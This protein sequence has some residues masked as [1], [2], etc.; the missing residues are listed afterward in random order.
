LLAYAF[1]TITA[2]QALNVR[3]G[4]TLTFNGDPA[5]G[6]DTPI[7]LVG[8]TLADIGLGLA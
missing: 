5:D 3:V 4:D 1:D 6:A 7:M 2:E 8:R